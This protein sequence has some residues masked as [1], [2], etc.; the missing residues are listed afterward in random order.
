MHPPEA[1]RRVVS[2]VALANLAYFFV[3][4]G[5]ARRIGSVALLSDSIDFLEDASVNLLIVMA[6]GWSL[7]SR[8][9]VGFLMGF[10]LLFPAAAALFTA[11]EKFINPAA[12]DPVALSTTALGALL[13]NLV[14]AL[15][16][17]RYRNSGGSL[18]RA[19]FLSARNDAFANIAVI[20]AGLVTLMWF[21]GWPDLVVGLTIAALNIGAAKEVWEEA[22]SERTGALTN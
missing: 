8:A 1:L 20:A 16:L 9:R 6:M 11:W 3:E 2:I 17:A 5:V 10:L 18:T 13:V 21:S 14:C 4:F 22:R 15:L 19:A 12:P 7:K